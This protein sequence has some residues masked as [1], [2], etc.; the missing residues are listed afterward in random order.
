M[1]KNISFLK[2]SSQLKQSCY[3]CNI[4][5]LCIAATL[6][7]SDI[8]KLDD[9]VTQHKP[10]SKGDML[11]SRGDRFQSVFI[12][13][14]GSIKTYIVDS[15]N[16]KKI[17][18]FYFPGDLIGLNAISANIY[19]DYAEVLETSTICQAPFEQLDKLS[20]YLPQLRR[21]ILQLMSKSIFDEQQMLQLLAQKN[22]D[23]R[24]ATFL[25]YVSNHFKT[26]GFSG[27][28]FRLS[29]SR[30]EIGSYLGLTTETV[31][32]TLS[33]LQKSNYLV[34][35]K[36]EIGILN[37]A[38]LLTLSGVPN[39]SSSIPTKRSFQIQAQP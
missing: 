12:I 39:I 9:I 15:S 27:S 7:S 22:A 33:R 8:S 30:Y 20:V 1:N 23:Q 16:I 2:A 5:S 36:K 17:T 18:G 6:G 14:T 28:R 19:Y 21:K 35:E 31:S 29:M 4:N 34:A 13:K 3:H 32:R 38:A 25:L 24:I 26:R 11:Y 37:F 10:L